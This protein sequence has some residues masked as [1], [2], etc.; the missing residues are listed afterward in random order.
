VRRTVRQLVIAAAGAAAL[1]VFSTPAQAALSVRALWNMDQLPTMV[2][3]AGGDNN[4][5]TRNIT[6]SAGAYQFNGTSSYATA[7]DKG[8]LD[9]GTANV[10]L[11]ARISI[12]KV[13]NVGQTF[14]VVRKGIKTT[15]GGY[16]KMEIVR[17]SNG[18]AVAACR[19]KDGN[20]GGA[21]T[22]IGTAGL[23]G[24]GFVTITCAKDA[25]TVAVSAGGQT[26]RLAKRIGSIS[27]SSPVNIGS[28]GDG[29]DWFPGLMDFVKIEIG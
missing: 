18:Q 1:V 20:G 8:N 28:K 25:S 17:S 12:T 24:R 2:D 5:T 26:T 19:Y 23:A 3:S 6:L 7:P 13:P 15:A 22:V 11:T 4:G 21:A 9:P 10:L 16:Y 14:D 27:N 29:T